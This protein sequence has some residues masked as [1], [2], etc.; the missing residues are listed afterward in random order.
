MRGGVIL[1]VTDFPGSCSSLRKL[2]C[3]LEKGLK[4]SFLSF[5]VGIVCTETIITNPSLLSGIRFFRY[6]LMVICDFH[7]LR[8]NWRAI[9]TCESSDFCCFSCWMKLDCYMSCRLNSNFSQLFLNFF[10]PLH[11]LIHNANS[12]VTH[13]FGCTQH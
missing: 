9:L 11:F 10:V 1:F 13:R 5:S 3:H 12:V 7:F 6:S 8:S 4:F 2:H